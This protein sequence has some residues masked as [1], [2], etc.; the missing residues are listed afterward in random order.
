ME[1]TKK[2]NP[3]MCPICGKGEWIPR[4]GGVHCFKHKKRT[5]RVTGMHDAVCSN[6]GTR[7]FIEG[8]I[9]E[10][11]RLIAEYERSLRDFI[12]PDDIYAIREKYLLSQATADKIFCCGK[13][14]FSKWERGDSTPTGTAALTLRRALRDE[15]FMKTLADEAGEII[16]FI[17]EADDRVQ[18]IDQWAKRLESI[19]KSIMD[20]QSTERYLILSR[21]TDFSFSDEDSY[22]YE[23]FK[24]EI[25][26]STLASCTQISAARIRHCNG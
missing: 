1:M 5:H 9:E 14:M 15:S 12:S 13:N 8:Q 3:E 7:G 11:K 25:S 6:C 18:E 22:D 24:N 19:R 2:F 21:N 26:K 20:V 16:E 10:N 4:E 23:S 17:G